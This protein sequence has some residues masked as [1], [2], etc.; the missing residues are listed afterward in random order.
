MNLYNVGEV[1]K[2][3]QYILK[4]DTRDLLKK[5]SSFPEPTKENTDDVHVHKL[6][7][8]R[9]YFLSHEV[10]PE[11]D[12]IIKGFF[13]YL[14]ILYSFDHFWWERIDEAIYYIK[15]MEWERKYKQESPRPRWWNTKVSLTDKKTPL[16]ERLTKAV[17]YLRKEEHYALNRDKDEGH[18]ERAKRLKVIQCLVEGVPI[19]Y[20]EQDVFGVLI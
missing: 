16:E 10:E 20:D 11:Q 14:I 4:K 19:E 6:I 7:D 2:F 17:D 15:G 5:L 13:N 1:G 18:V 3:I 12:K 9:D 8:M